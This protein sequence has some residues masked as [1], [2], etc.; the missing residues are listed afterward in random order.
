MY[1]G[2]DI[3]LALV[4]L[5]VGLPLMLVIFI[6]GLFDTGRPLFYQKRVG[7]NMQIFV[8]IK[9]RTMAIGTVS[10]A[11]HFAPKNSITPFGNFL[12]KSKLDE[13][14]QLWNVLVGDMSLV[15]PRPNLPV[16]KELTVLRE[17]MNVYRVRPGITGL[18]QINGVDMSTPE[19]LVDLD[20]QMIKNMTHKNYFIY[21]L[22][23]IL[24]RGRGDA[25]LR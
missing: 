12:R 18:A 10:T 22:K 14:P 15:G 11:S 13:L 25:A 20:S 9:F 21:I 8:L 6:I 1:R 2:I 5:L 16:Q 23:T 24:G 17:K 7:K 19:I 4:G 3:M